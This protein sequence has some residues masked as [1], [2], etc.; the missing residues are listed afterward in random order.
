MKI[1]NIHGYQGDPHNAAFSALSEIGEGK[2]EIIS[3]AV[4]HD[5]ESPDKVIEDL[6]KIV[7]ENSIDLLTGTSLGGFYAAV[8][9]AEYDLPVIFV[10]PCLL[11]FD[12]LPRLGYTG[13]IRT[14]MTL[15]GKLMKLKEKNICTV[16]GGSDEVIDTP[17]ITRSMLSNDR[18]ICVPGGKHSGATLDLLPKFREFIDY[19]IKIKFRVFLTG[20]THGGLDMQKLSQTQLEKNDIRFTENDILIITGDFGFPFIPMDIKDYEHDSGDYTFWIKYLRDLP[21]KVLFIDGNH[22]NHDWWAKQ[23]VT[24]MF[25]GRVQIHPHAGNVIH[26][27]RGEVYTI[28]GKKYFTFGGALSIDKEYRTEGFSWWSGEEASED[29]KKHAMENLEKHGFKVDYIITHTMPNSIIAQLPMFEHKL[30]G[31]KTAAFLDEVLEKTEYEKW[32]CGHF[33]MDMPVSKYRLYV[34]Y[35]HIRTLDDDLGDQNP[36]F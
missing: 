36:V 27:M 6:R 24:E 3:P 16:V 10:N 19:I 30:D 35:N 15:F 32:F 12:V 17:E 31:C 34:L 13:D 26:L 9:S 28:N 18:F 8:L 4:D 11:P 20:D 33:H 22:D 21:C 29:E 2:F 7:E 1:L 5:K 14:Y 25:G 23:E